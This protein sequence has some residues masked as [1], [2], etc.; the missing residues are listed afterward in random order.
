MAIFGIDANM[1]TQV[2]GISWQTVGV[3]IGAFSALITALVVLQERRNRTIKDEIKSSV[4]HLSDVLLAKLE[5]K[6]SVARISERLAR[7]EGAASIS[8]LGDL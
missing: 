6:E 3:I 4:D 5:T 7:I 2:V 1:T 8:R